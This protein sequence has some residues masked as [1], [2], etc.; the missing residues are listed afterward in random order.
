MSKRQQLPPQIRKIEVRDRSTGKTVVRYQV[1]VD[2]GISPDTGK[3]KQT[4]MRFTAEK[5]ARDYLST[6]QAAVAVGTYVARSKRTVRQA[7]NEWVASKHNLKASTLLGHKS[8]LSAVTDELG[9]VE[10]QKLSKAHVD[11]LVKRLRAGEVEGRSAWSPRSVNYMLS[12]SRRRWS[13]S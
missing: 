3:R 12:I 13:P 9:G 4:R 10:V 6:T 8:K 7:V 11:E 2:A 1:T 5:D